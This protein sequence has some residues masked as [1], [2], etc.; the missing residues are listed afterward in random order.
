V[1]GSSVA[2]C[3]FALFGAVYRDMV[4]DVFFLT[5]GKGLMGNWQKVSWG[6][7]AVFQIERQMGENFLTSFRS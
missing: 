5:E 7:S 1:L 6:M 4:N 2:L 3:G